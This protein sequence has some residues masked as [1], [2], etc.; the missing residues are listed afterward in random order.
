[1]S[2]G[3]TRCSRPR[4]TAIET[5]ASIACSTSKPCMGSVTANEMPNSDREIR[6]PTSGLRTDPFATCMP[7]CER[8]GLLPAENSKQKGSSTARTTGVPPWPR[9][10]VRSPRNLRRRSSLSKIRLRAGGGHVRFGP[11]DE[12][13]RRRCCSFLAFRGYLEARNTAVVRKASAN[14]ADLTADYFALTLQENELGRIWSL[15]GQ[16]GI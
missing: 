12:R 2:N 5:A 14:P 8:G 1:M 15:N 6:R 16:S 13:W 11:N 7:S 3:R 9:R 10:R 4:F